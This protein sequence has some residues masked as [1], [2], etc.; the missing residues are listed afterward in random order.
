M[1]K[2]IL[3]SIAIAFLFQTSAHAQIPT[4]DIANIVSQGLQ[5]AEQILQYEQQVES[6]TKQ[7]EQYEQQVKSAESLGT[8][9]GGA[10]NSDQVSDIQK[11]QSVTRAANG[12][13]GLMGTAGNV[14]QKVQDNYGP[15]DKPADFNK[16]MG[17]TNDTIRGAVSSNAAAVDGMA[18]E[19][20]RLNSLV[21]QSN[22]ASGALQAAQAGN[23]IT[24]ELASQVQKQRQEQAIQSNAD[25]AA[26]LA[27]QRQA[28]SKEA[29]A[30][31][32]YGGSVQ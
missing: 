25:N 28:E 12:V 13:N 3:A 14:I 4:T 32:I 8:Q 21:S 2:K 20:S 24:A 29:A 16:Y 19:A 22:S 5:Y 30:R 9:L 27:R 1:L 23:Q 11:V 15:D 26:A 31:Y 17:A 7:I 10:L 18:G 6:Y